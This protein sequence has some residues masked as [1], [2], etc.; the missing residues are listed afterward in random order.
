M[1]FQKTMFYLPHFHK[2]NLR[3]LSG[4]MR[5]SRLSADTAANIRKIKVP[6][7]SLSWLRVHQFKALNVSLDC[8][9]LELGRQHN[10]TP[11]IVNCWDIV[12]LMINVAN[13]KQIY[14]SQDQDVL[15]ETHKAIGFWGLHRT[16]QSHLR[17]YIEAYLDGHEHKL[18]I[19]NVGEVQSEMETTVV[20]WF[21]ITISEK[22]GTERREVIIKW[23]TPF[24][25]DVSLH[26][27]ARKEAR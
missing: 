7:N 16:V 1:A 20:R 17:S 15:E 26:K 9:E 23:R 24:T 22:K 6:K 14:V 27:T 11:Q 13:L 3:E 10:G 25:S 5:S 12:I 21:P 18:W 4:R 8:I 19:H 2:L